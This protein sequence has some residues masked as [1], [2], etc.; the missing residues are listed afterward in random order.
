MRTYIKGHTGWSYKGARI[1]L[2]TLAI[3][4]QPI[5]A[6]SSSLSSAESDILV[7]QIDLE[8]RLW[9]LVAWCL[10]SETVY[11]LIFGRRSLLLLIHSIFLVRPGGKH[12]FLDLLLLVLFHRSACKVGRSLELLLHLVV[13]H[14]VSS[15]HH[16]ARLL[17]NTREAGPCME[18]GEGRS[19]QNVPLPVLKPGCVRGTEEGFH[20]HHFLN[21]HPKHSSDTSHTPPLDPLSASILHS[22]QHLPILPK[23]TP[24]SR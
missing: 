8:R 1:H 5:F 6:F 23:W 15:R 10:R 13:A 9:C 20:F 12:D 3:A 4:K 14:T 11:T 2:A 17:T 18:T 16:L 24:S 19:N 7:V 21:I 22:Q